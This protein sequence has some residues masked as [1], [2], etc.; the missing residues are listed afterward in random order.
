MKR[1]TR[2]LALLFVFA[3]LFS[4][5]PEL[6]NDA[7]AS[8]ST[9]W[10]ATKKCVVYKQ[11]DTS[12]KQLGTLYFGD[13]LICEDYSSKKTGWARV[14]NSR[15]RVGYCKMSLLTD[16]NPSTLEITL[17]ATKTTRVY[18]A[19]TAGKIKRG[20]VKKGTE[21]TAVGVTPDLKWWRALGK[22]SNV[23]YFIPVS[24]F[25]GTD[26]S[27]F[28]GKSADIVNSKNKVIGTLSYCEGVSVL[29]ETKGVKLVYFDTNK[30]GYVASDD[31][32]EL[33]PQGMEKTAYAAAD[34]VW[35]YNEAVF[36]KGTG[37]ITVK[38][39]T[40]ITLLNGSDELGYYRVRYKKKNY[41]VLANSVFPEKSDLYALY[42]PGAVKLYKTRSFTSKNLAGELK[43]GEKVAVRAVYNN[44]VKV[45][46]E[47][48]LSG[49]CALS[50][51]K[52]SE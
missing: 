10:V 48:G 39:N 30:L 44:K 12:S 27:Y 22:K 40:A 13:S 35:L 19:P 15:G 43:S 51:L 24:S 29:D 41:Y 23:Y 7:S 32:E 8:T 18:S 1:L 21:I 26:Y 9:V 31:F 20:S 46:N 52:R 28:T 47:S 6:T 14:M 2:A 36:K 45:E 25:T 38:K 11:K 49:W 3:L 16:D 34:S 4:F 17:R 42:A 50:S 5:A 37:H 33:E